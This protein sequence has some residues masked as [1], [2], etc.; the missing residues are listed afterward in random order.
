[1]VFTAFHRFAFQLNLMMI[2]P[3]WYLEQSVNLL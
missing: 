3:Y 1:V 2:D